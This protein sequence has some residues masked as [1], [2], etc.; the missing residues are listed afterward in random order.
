MKA[1]RIRFAFLLGVE[2]EVTGVPKNSAARV[3]KALKVVISYLLIG[4]IDSPVP[5]GGLAKRDR[6]IADISVCGIGPLASHFKSKRLPFFENFPWHGHID[7][8]K[9]IRD[10]KVALLRLK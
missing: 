9:P 2:K 6:R 7:F 10:F 5:H 1:P 8:I 3:I 4:F